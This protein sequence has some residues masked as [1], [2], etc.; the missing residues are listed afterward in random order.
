[1]LNNEIEA[2]RIKDIL[3]ENEI[4]HLIRNFHDSA[5]DGLFQYQIGWGV[6]EAEESDEE[7]ILVLLKELSE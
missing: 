1:M 3:D 5:Y 6:L 2:L 4:A 7:K